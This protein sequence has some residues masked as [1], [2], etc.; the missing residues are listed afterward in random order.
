[1]RKFYQRISDLPNDWVSLEDKYYRK[2]P[3]GDL[4]LKEC[5]GLMDYQDLNHYHYT[6]AQNGGP[7]GKSLET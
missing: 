2:I 1:M 3:M 7:I 5:V 4:E 6:Q